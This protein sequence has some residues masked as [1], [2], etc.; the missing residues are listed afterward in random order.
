MRFE[1][2]RLQ[3]HAAVIMPNHIHLLIEPLGENTLPTLLKGIKGASA[4]KANQ[5]IDGNGQFWLDE[6]YD[7]IVRSE[8]QYHRFIRYIT[9]NP[10][11][12]G[13]KEHEYWLHQL[14][15]EADIAVCRTTP[16]TMT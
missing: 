13:L 1:G 2:D 10:V 8:A 12:A 9:A 14:Q 11:K 3:L 6:S 4:R 5:I 15:G 16:Y 7:H